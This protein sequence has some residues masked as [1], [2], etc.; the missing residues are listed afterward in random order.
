MIE[1]RQLVRTFD[2]DGNTATALDQLDFDVERG[3][4]RALLGPNGAGKTTLVRILSTVLLPTSGTARVNGH[5]VVDD[6]D[7]VRRSLRLSLGGDRG[8]HFGLSVFE[9]VRF[10]ATMY[11]LGWR[12]STM[13]ALLCHAYLYNK[14]K[15]TFRHLSFVANYGKNMDT[16]RLI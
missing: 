3:E 6:A 14:I 12:E 13:L 9:N 11:G 8:F 10:W 5:D 1:C 4:T 15:Q 2:V 7:E 16:L